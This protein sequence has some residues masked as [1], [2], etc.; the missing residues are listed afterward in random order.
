MIAHPHCRAGLAAVL[1]AAVSLGGAAAQGGA[2]ADAVE[3]AAEIAA[4]DAE[5]AAPDDVDRRAVERIL[6]P[7][8]GLPPVP[9]PAH[10]PP[11]PAEVA[12]GRKLFFDRRLSANG[13]LSC[14]VCHVPEQGFTVHE[15]ATAVGFNGKSLL[16]NS[17]GLLNVA[18]AAPFFHDGR[19]P[20]LD[21]QAFDVLLNPDEMAMPSIGAVVARVAALDDYRPL[22][23][24]AFGGVPTVERIGRALA[25]YMRSLLAGDSAFDRWRYGGDPEA[26]PATA[27][28]GFALFTGRAGC[29]SCHLVGEG[30]A[31][32]TD[33]E[34]HDTGIASRSAEARRSASVRVELAP[35][36]FTELDRAVVESV[37]DPRRED[38]GRYRVSEDPA[39]L[40][41]FKTPTLRNVALTP[42]YMHDGS[43]ATLREVVEHYDRGGHAHD[44]LDPKIVPLGLT[45]D[46]IEDLVA[47]L[48]SLTGAGVRELIADARRGRPR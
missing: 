13:S 21:L 26:L 24:A 10:G 44:G 6:A 45:D 25:S 9:I 47:F 40:R 48:E 23:A 19:E 15:L 41:R 22:F 3:P 1:A 17:P 18:Y 11:T 30:S 31:L 35:G 28:R 14:G 43:L 34:F 38:L 27:R 8:L 5:I 29:S 36:L 4:P 12:L 32:F 7:P 42:P 33:G 2:G 37:G 46:E 39:D 20:S 16:R